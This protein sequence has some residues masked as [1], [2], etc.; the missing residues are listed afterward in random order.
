MKLKSSVFWFCSL[1]FISLSLQSLGK[2]SLKDKSEPEKVKY[3]SLNYPH[4]AIQ[5]YKRNA[6][7]LLTQSNEETVSIYSS[8]LVA[9]SNLHDIALVTEVVQLLSDRR[10]SALRESY[11][12]TITNA[13]GI[14]YGMNEQYYDAIATYKCTLKHAN[15]QLDKMIAKINLAIAYRMNDQPAQGFQIL[16]SIEQAI[17]TG[18]RK[19]GLLVVSGN[20]SIAL[21]QIDS[22]ITDYTEARR[23]YLKGDNYRNAARVSVN[24]LSAILLDRRTAMY[25]E[26]RAALN[27]HEEAYLT[28]NELM[29]LKWLD[30]MYTSIKNN[31]ISDE[32]VKY[33]LSNATYLVKGG[34]ADSVNKLLKSLNSEH[35][36]VVAEKPLTDRAVLREG[37]A[38][39]WCH[40]V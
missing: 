7:R 22:A 6:A 29:F 1:L 17:L 39:P 40:N 4:Q 36:M 28:E 3:L 23:Y 38:E 2:A 32:A 21:G 35:L 18:R 25:D 26:Y 11:G 15:N 5:F 37:L 9:A 10:L 14:S 19:A 30:L 24:L 16:Q 27:T 34:Y 8:V 33:T 20:L 12:F 31:V 13:I